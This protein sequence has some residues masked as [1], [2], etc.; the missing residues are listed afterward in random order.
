MVVGVEN[1]VQ[2]T[3]ADIE[4]LLANVRRA[5]DEHGRG[6]SA[7]SALHEKRATPPPVLRIGGIAR[8]PD[9]ANARHAA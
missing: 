8:A 6:A 3:R 7:V 5:V 1:A 4:Q 9:I 2:P